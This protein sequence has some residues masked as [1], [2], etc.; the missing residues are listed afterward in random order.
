M[1]NDGTYKTSNVKNERLASDESYEIETLSQMIESFGLI[2]LIGISDSYEKD[3]TS[4]E[5]NL[6]IEDK[7]SERKKIAFNS[8]DILKNIYERVDNL[9]KQYH[10][11]IKKNYETMD[12]VK[13]YQEL[14]SQNNFIE[15]LIYEFILQISLYLGCTYG[16]APQLNAEF[17][18]PSLA[19]INSAQSSKTK[20][21]E[22]NNLKNIN[23]T[24]S[25]KT[26]N[27]ELSNRVAQ[28]YGIEDVSK[29][30]E[31]KFFSS[32]SFIKLFNLI[33]NDLYIAIHSEEELKSK[34]LLDYIIA[35][36]SNELMSMNIEGA[37][38]LCAIGLQL[39]ITFH[40]LPQQAQPRH[41]LPPV[42]R[43]KEQQLMKHQLRQ[44]VKRS[45]H[46]K[47]NKISFI[48]KNKPGYI[49]RI[50]K[51]N[52]I[53]ENYTNKDAGYF[54]INRNRNNKIKK[55]FKVR[56][57]ATIKRLHNLRLHKS[58]KHKSK[59]LRKYKSIFNKT[60]KKKI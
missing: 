26:I 17:V 9:K 54:S 30:Y 51:L 36:C 1:L 39:P 16:N 12:R 49:N 52:N 58:R 18:Q 3:K 5:N 53:T 60:L 13:L 24:Q 21:L 37:I 8:F 50:N 32:Q 20:N 57:H 38:M 59:N 23:K 6:S 11:F 44:N 31:Y 46:L 15:Y 4:K 22:L 19:D 34:Q 41:K 29:L 42:I 7:I 55:K 28:V 25:G 2:D 43:T 47:P 27:L 45:H 10:S 48:L 40:Y 35:K 33:Y 14:Y 56:K